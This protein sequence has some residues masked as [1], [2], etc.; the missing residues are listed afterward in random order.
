LKYEYNSFLSR[1]EMNTPI[2]LIQDMAREGWRVVGMMRVRPE[3]QFASVEVLF[4]RPIPE[5]IHEWEKP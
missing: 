1:D 2:Q 5:V 4:E 3:T